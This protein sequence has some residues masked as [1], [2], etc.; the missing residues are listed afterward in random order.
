MS[1]WKHKDIWKRS[2]KNF[3]VEISRHEEGVPEGYCYDSEGPHRWCV[4]AY[5][6]PRHPRFAKFEGDH[7]WQEAT[8]LGFHG[9]CSYLRRH[10]SKGEV[11][12]IQCGADYNHDGDWH[13]TQLATQKEAYE[14]FRDA[15]ELFD[16]LTSLG[17]SA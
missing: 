8:S 14:V 6:Y 11:T 16:L 12:A 4:Y 13:F 17:E 10:E 5:I 7:L 1:D 3:M 2:G 15:D 9:G